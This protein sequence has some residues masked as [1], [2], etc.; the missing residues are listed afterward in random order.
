MTRDARGGRG[1]L[2]G[3]RRCPQTT[4][5]GQ[6][7][8]DGQDEGHNQTSHAKEEAQEQEND[9][10][11]DDADGTSDD[12]DGVVVPVAIFC[13]DPQTWG[14][15]GLGIRRSVI[16]DKDTIDHSHHCRWTHSPGVSSPPCLSDALS[17]SVVVVCPLDPDPH[18][19]SHTHT[20]THTHTHARA[21]ARAGKSSLLFT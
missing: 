17:L 16:I 18:F 15:R 20:H 12:S 1:P 21:R 5:V 9:G 4:S 3:G 2:L 13:W 11:D 8:Q 19:H 6:H 14:G 10:Q 7:Y